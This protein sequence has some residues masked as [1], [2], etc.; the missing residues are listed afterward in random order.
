MKGRKERSKFLRVKCPDCGKTQVIFEKPSTRVDC[1]V[2]GRTL[3]DPT[4]GKG[5]IL[6]EVLEVL[7]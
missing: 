7:E 1:L 5:K 4:G 2:C 6:G 3:A